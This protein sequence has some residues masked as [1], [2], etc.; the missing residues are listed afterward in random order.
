MF[1]GTFSLRD[2][3]PG[4]C[5]FNNITSQAVW[6]VSS[7]QPGSGIQNLFDGNRDTYWQSDG[8]LPHQII[9]QFAKKMFISVVKIAVSTQDDNYAPLQVDIQTGNDPNSMN[10]KGTFA[11]ENFNGVNT[12]HIEIEAIFLAILIVRN[13]NDGKNSKIRSLQVF[14]S[15][16]TI[17]PEP[18][19]AFKKPELAMHLGIR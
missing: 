15:L 11:I 3:K 1:K 8:N 6:T 7:T 9:A 5:P 13:L 17:S 19:F 4:N 14:G 10:S 18:S 16:R 12:F 2:E